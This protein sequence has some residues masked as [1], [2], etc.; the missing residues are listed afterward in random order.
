MRFGALGRTALVGLVASLVI[1]GC[2][3]SGEG[4][5]GTTSASSEMKTDLLI[6]QYPGADSA[7]L[8]IAME[9]GFFKEEGLTV[10]QEPIQ[11]PQAVLPKLSNGTMDVVLGSY[12]TILTIQEA[13]TE[14][15]KYIADSYQGAA[16][17]FGIMVKKG[18]TIKDVAGLKGKRVG[19]NAL[20]GLGTLTMNPHFKIAGLDPKT[21]IK[22]VE[23]PTTNW[24]SSLDK[25]DVDAVW[26]TDPYVSEAK[27]T[28]GATMLLDTMSGPTDGLPIT[29]WA[30]TEKW[31]SEN[32][33]T[34]AAFQRAMAKAQNIAAT[35]RSAVTK[36]LPTFTKIPAET[37]ATINL[38]DYPTSLS[39][40]R[41]QRVADLMLDAGMLKKQIDVKSMIYTA[42]QG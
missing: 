32:P 12:A 39:A 7:P 13:G 30:A 27:K 17:A 29:G 14:K 9:R 41:I 4:G 11:A 38:G 36:V 42:P 18:S 3:S 15:F 26:M 10:K 23:V 5:G 40:D 34:L 6:G 16:G 31:V 20:A 33:K 1:T 37:A 8:F 2:S 28:L 35:D 19:V 22:Y 21:D 25:G 24:L